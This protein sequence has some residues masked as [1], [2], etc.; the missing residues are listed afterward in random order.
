MS[1]DSVAKFATSRLR[2]AYR[3]EL[4]IPG[5]SIALSALVIAGVLLA[6]CSRGVPLRSDQQ[7]RMVPA[8]QAFAMPEVGGP[9][10][11]AV[12]E[13]RYANA[14]EQD[15]LLATS[16]ATPGQNLLRIQIF[17]PVETAIANRDTLRAGYLPAKNVNSE[18]RELIPG[19][20]MKTSGY[21]V[22]NKYG[23]FGYAVGR[24]SSGDTCLYA[25]QR[26]TSTGF[27][28]T[29]IGN[30][31]SIQVRLRL[32]DQNA[33]EQRLLQSMYGYTINASFKSRNWNPFGEPLPPDE[34][35]GR[36]GAPTYPVS[37]PR[38]ET[39]TEPI[40]APAPK[41]RSPTRRQAANPPVPATTRQPVP[42]GPTVPPPPGDGVA[43]SSQSGARTVQAPASAPPQGGAPLVPPPPQ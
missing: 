7:T 35:L 5:F 12:L 43:S 20:R 40:A 29:W 39:V 14:T 6:G 22:Q 26:I 27:T 37:A 34:T 41:R 28:Q 10:V 18:M 24:T 31:G 19:V 16:A 13:K 38:F 17:G 4:N 21:Y 11:T 32:C 8:E 3:S 33:S 1:T 15:V 2:S 36:P 23:P 25:W 42:V 30:K 9:A